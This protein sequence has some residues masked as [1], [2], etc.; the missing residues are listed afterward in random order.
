MGE[1]GS[2]THALRLALA[3]STSLRGASGPALLAAALW[4]APMPVAAQ[5]ANMGANGA[6]G[7]TYADGSTVN[8]GGVSA[9]FGTNGG[10][11][12]AGG[13]GGTGGSGVVG[14]GLTINT[15]SA[16]I[17]SGGNGGAGGVGG[18]GV[19][20]HLVQRVQ[21]IPQARIVQLHAF[22]ERDLRLDL[23]VG[24]VHLPVVFGSFLPEVSHRQ[25]PPSHALE[26]GVTPIN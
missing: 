21:G 6:P 4:L 18:A 23:G 26:Q 13:A 16:N 17:I 7:M 14:N 25:V 3:G 12:G 20:L 24:S 11:G 19:E 2:T 8:L 22:D 1:R 15:T 10:P 9:I 5:S